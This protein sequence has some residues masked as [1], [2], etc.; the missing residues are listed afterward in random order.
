MLVGR[1]KELQEL[2]E[3]YDATRANGNTIYLDAYDSADLADWFILQQ[4][5]EKAE[6]ILDLGLKMHPG[7]TTLLI[8][9]SYFYL[10]NGK[11]SEAELLA[12]EINEPESDEV[13]I[14]KACIA[15]KANHPQVAEF[16]LDELDEPNDLYNISDICYAYLEADLSNKAMEW[17]EKG[18]GLYD[19]E[20]AF[21]AVSADCYYAQ[22]MY[23]E[24]ITSFNKLIDINP[25]SPVY[26]LGLSKCHFVCDEF[27]QCIDACDY[28]LVIDEEYAEAYFIR[29]QAFYELGNKEKA[30]NDMEK[31]NQL[32]FFS[33][34]NLSLFKC[35]KLMD[36]T[37]YEEAIQVLLSAL[38]EEPYNSGYV[39]EVK[40]S[41]IYFNIAQC[42]L[43]MNML[44]K[45]KEY[46]SRTIHENPKE[47][48]AH[49]ILGR[50]HFIENDS[51]AALNHFQ[52]AIRISPTADTW[53][54]IGK[55]A[56]EMGAIELA[57]KAFTTIKKLEPERELINEKLVYMYLISGNFDELRKLNEQLPVPF[58]NEEIETM[59][60]LLSTGEVEEIHKVAQIMS[61][62]IIHKRN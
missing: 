3:K 27:N 34:R 11:I 55:Q 10:D 14:L 54:E 61:S 22:E 12:S 20:E 42:Y 32:G 39:P 25:Y 31:S 41:T 53:N 9:K 23:E 4:Q 47:I 33:N 56:I 38:H 37:N 24:A 28:A 5:P 44:D 6:E 26:W 36:E 15:M 30:L 45:A 43:E 18:K 35:I 7:N 62:K 19:D 58:T 2:A 52:E 21:L 48:H 60:E 49:L 1:D 8:E 13:R 51:A 59:K 40:D 50:I 46:A 16:F 17:L 57:I 29:A